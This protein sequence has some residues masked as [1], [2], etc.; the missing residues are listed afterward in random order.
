MRAITNPGKVS[1]AFP[2]RVTDMGFLLSKRDEASLPVTG[3]H[4]PRRIRQ[5]R[6]RIRRSGFPA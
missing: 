3:L 2:F 4:D 1:Q 5:Y 6:R